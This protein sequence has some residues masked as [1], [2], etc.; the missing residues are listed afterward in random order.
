MGLGERR[1]AKNF[2]TNQLPALKKEID[3]AA[4]FD[5]PLEINWE[6]LSP[7]G[8]AHLYEESWTKVY[9]RP[10]VDALKAICVDDMGKEALKGA[11]KKVVIKN[12]Q[13]VYYGD[14]IATFEG[15]VLTL[16]HEP[17]TNIDDVADRAKGIQAM[18]EKNL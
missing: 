15:G 7:E 3:Q 8:Q 2:E 5:V 4:G 6:Q 18:L 14:R 11:L 12:S 13:N 17:T 1:A 16:D 9:F 10:L